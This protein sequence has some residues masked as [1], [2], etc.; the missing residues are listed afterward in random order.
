MRPAARRRPR[1]LLALCLA[2][3][4][5]TVLAPAGCAGKATSRRGLPRPLELPD[6]PPVAMHVDDPRATLELAGPALGP[7]A[8]GIRPMLRDELARHVDGDTA[9]A[10]VAAIDIE[11]P[12]DLV[13]LPEGEEILH[14][15][16]LGAKVG[17]V[18]AALSSLPTEGDFGARRLTRPARAGGR[19]PAP[20]VLVWVDEKAETLTF[21]DSLRGLATGPELEGAYGHH[22]VFATVD[23]ALLD[24]RL[25]LERVRL[26]GRLEDFELRATLREGEKNPRKQVPLT[27][28]AMSGLLAHP[29]MVAAI[30]SRYSKHEQ[31]VNEQLDDLR[32]MVKRQNFFVQGIL[33]DMVNKLAAVLRSWDGRFVAGIGPEGHLMLAYGAKDPKKSGRDVLV[34]VGTVIDNIKL[35]RN[36]TSKVP[37]IS[38]KRNAAQVGDDPIH[39]III[40]GIQSEVPKSMRSLLDDKGRLRLAF[41]FPRHA[42]GGVITVGPR[43]VPMLE[44]WLQE[45]AKAPSGADTAKDYAA[46]AV[47][48]PPD[49]LRKL[50]EV[51]DPSRLVGTLKARGPHRLAVARFEGDREVV[52]K[53]TSKQ[54]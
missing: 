28:G 5:L 36:F 27:E 8:E 23:G 13:R 46:L 10:I 15:H 35:A 54:P 52:V 49:D 44:K 14:V 22:P 34:L 25:P 32:R 29:G 17:D 41:A 43:P 48:L 38:I 11:A 53:V 26:E 39:R 33:A 3:A 19:E 40:A 6:D 20:G 30:S 24:D 18:T 1:L 51:D 9:K 7:K 12:M 45:S 31:V 42:G 47:R 50:A 4:S 37:K 21:A 2:T 16:L